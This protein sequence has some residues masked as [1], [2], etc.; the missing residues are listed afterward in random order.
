M[1]NIRE[2]ARRSGVSVAT[3]SR[4][5]KDPQMVSPRTR[6]RVLKAVEEAGYRPNMLA[7][8][9]SS[10]KSFAVMVL[11]PNIANPFFSKVIRGIEKAAQDQGYSV[12]LG[13]TKGEPAHEQFYAG[14]AL[15]NQ[16]DGLIQ[17][18][19]RYPFAEKDAAL[20]A[21]I[22]MV[23]A[24]ERIAEDDRYPVVEL[25]N[26]GAAQ[27][28]ARHLIELGHRRIGIVTGPLNS[29]IVRDRLVGFEE[30]MQRHG[31]ELNSDLVVNGEFTMPSGAEGARKLLSLA[32][33]PTAIFCM[34]DEMAIGAVHQAKEMGLQVPADVSVA[35]FDNIE[36]SQFTDPPLTTIDQPA[37]K[38]GRYAM[39]TLRRIIDG[40]PL[41]ASRTILP[42]DL[43]VRGSTA[44]YQD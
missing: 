30:E 25:D 35:G 11:V 4:A 24:C 42:F 14:M 44:R 31:L 38:L 34:N 7:R 5:L 26:S 41:K 2:V 28:M 32:S 21:S 33:A 15:T 40:K 6:E 13:D 10:G 43:V 17:L 36:F 9:F 27:A 37:E 39:E 12:L 29:P 23:N 18:D 22:P 19:S 8:N 20:A 3:V 1:S 16:A